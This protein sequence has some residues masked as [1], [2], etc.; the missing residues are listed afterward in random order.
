M[1]ACGCLCAKARQYHRVS[2]EGW[3]SSGHR[4]GKLAVVPEEQQAL[5]VP[6]ALCGRHQY[7]AP[8]RPWRYE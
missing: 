4:S 3:D 6:R 7:G 2:A 1:G 8:L 5:R